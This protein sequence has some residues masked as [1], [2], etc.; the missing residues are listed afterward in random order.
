MSWFLGLHGL[1]GFGFGTHF[2]VRF[3]FVR[4]FEDGHPF[5]VKHLLV[6]VHV[7][8]TNQFG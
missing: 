8:V 1:K 7:A 2:V 3:K 4:K 6:A 5:A